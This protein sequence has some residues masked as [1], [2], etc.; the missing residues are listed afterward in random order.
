MELQLRDFMN[1]IRDFELVSMLETI[2]DY[3]VKLSYS[4]LVFSSFHPYPPLSLYPFIFLTVDEREGESKRRESRV[5]RE[6]ERERE[7]EGDN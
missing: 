5:Y 2:T 1:I 3:R 4:F 7:E 6:E